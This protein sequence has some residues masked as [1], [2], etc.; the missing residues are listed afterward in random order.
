M[1]DMLRKLHGRRERIALEMVTRGAR[2]GFSLVELAIVLVIIGLVLGGVLKGQALIE[3][4]RI[5]A[6]QT[7]VNEV[8][9]ATATFRNVYVAMPGDMVDGT[10]VGL[11]AG[12]GGDGNGRIG[13]ARTSD[14]RMLGRGSEAE[15]AFAHLGAAG[16]L[17]GVDPAGI[18]DDG[19][20]AENGL[21]AAI[22]GFFTMKYAIIGLGYDGRQTPADHWLM[23]GSMTGP[24]WCA[25]PEDNDCPVMSPAGLRSL[26]VKA[27]DGAPATGAIR[28]GSG[29]CVAAPERYRTDAGGAAVCIPVFR[30]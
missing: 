23:L 18:V 27:D 24:A 4:A 9:T 15:L 13:T 20:D 8:R 7:T 5:N 6:V 21:D 1:A 29:A 3:S 16:F 17:R 10:R 25:D 30:L 28:G 11:A 22:G 2:Q 14:T 19:L 12:D 26:D